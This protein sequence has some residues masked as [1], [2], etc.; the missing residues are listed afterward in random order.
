LDCVKL[1]NVIGLIF[2]M[3]GVAIVFVW[4]PPQ[5]NFESG[6]GLGLEANTPL[7]SGKTVAENDRETQLRKKRYSLMSR[8]GLIFLFIGFVFQLLATV[9]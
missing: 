5:P 7:P 4:G 2:G 6:T 9:W 3:I 1:L 8:F